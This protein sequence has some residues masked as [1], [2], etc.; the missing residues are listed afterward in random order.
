MAEGG[1]V[2]LLDPATYVDG[3]PHEWFARVR[4]DDPVH[5][6]DEAD[7]PG[8]WV[9]TR[10]RDVLAVSQAWET[11]SSEAKGSMLYEMGDPD[12][13][14]HRQLLVGMDPPRHTRYRLLVNR[15]FTPKTDTPVPHAA[16]STE[17]S[18]S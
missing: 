12:L 18:S 10:H 11:F 7:G 9:L 8:F 5:W 3:P 16:A 15:A 17:P 2:D 1:R 6:E 13:A 14:V 4:E